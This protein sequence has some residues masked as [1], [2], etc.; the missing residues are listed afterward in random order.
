MAERI[1]MEKLS[2]ELTDQ[3]KLIEAGWIGLRLATINKDASTVQIND[4]RMAFFAG[5]QHL[6]AS[7]ITILDPGDDATDADLTRMDR[8]ADELEEFSK[9]LLKDLPTK[10]TG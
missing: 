2:R 10:G 5:A 9:Q 4:L 6:F 7:I 3:G 8:I 1:D